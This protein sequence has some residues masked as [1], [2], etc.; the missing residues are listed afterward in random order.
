[1]RLHVSGIAVQT[2][3]NLYSK[4]HPMKSSHYLKSPA[5]DNWRIIGLL[6]AG[7]AGLGVERLRLVQG[8]HFD[9]WRICV[10]SLSR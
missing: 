6:T 2:S 9:Q 7:P 5:F 8:R 10:S 4:E 3:N 1:M